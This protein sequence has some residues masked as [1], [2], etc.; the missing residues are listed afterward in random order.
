VPALILAALSVALGFGGEFLIQLA[1][2]AS[3]ALLN[4]SAYVEAVIG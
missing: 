1:E 3:G 4:T 2:Q